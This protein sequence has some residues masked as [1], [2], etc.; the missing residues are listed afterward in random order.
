MLFPQKCHLIHSILIFSGHFSI[1][2]HRQHRDIVPHSPLPYPSL[3]IHTGL[4]TNRVFP[5]KTPK[6][7]KYFSTH[8]PNSNDH[9]SQRANAF[10]T[11]QIHFE[12]SCLPLILVFKIQRTNSDEP[13]S[14]TQEN[15]ISFTFI[16]T[17]FLC[18]TVKLITTYVAQAG[19]K[20]MI[21]L[22]S[23]RCWNYW[24][25]APYLAP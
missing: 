18:S 13:H 5:M 19:L 2:E 9:T 21:L 14:N 10:C 8:I 22:Q 12:I 16:K 1:T 4:R 15:H 25:V 23:P 24:C 3:P 20:L 11:V 17:V 7:Q 6:Y